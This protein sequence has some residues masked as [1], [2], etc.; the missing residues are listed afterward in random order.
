[1]NEAEGWVRGAPPL[2]RPGRYDTIVNGRDPIYRYR[3][4]VEMGRVLWPE[5]AGQPLKPAAYDI[6]WHRPVGIDAAATAVYS[7]LT[8]ARAELERAADKLGDLLARAN[9]LIN[10]AP[11]PEADEK[12]AP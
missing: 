4:V 12:P 5:L 6:Y 7:H 2:D 8:A 11:L 1:M 10:Y 9:R 3:C